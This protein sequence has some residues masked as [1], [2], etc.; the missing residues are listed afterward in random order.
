[1]PSLTSIARRLSD[2]A[3]GTA[4]DRALERSRGD[5]RNAYLFFWNRGLGDIALGLVPLFDRILERSP[6]AR[7][8]VITR[9]ELRPAF[10]L[11]DASEIHVLSGL[12]R[13]ARVSLDAACRA[14]DLDRA[15]FAE[16][17]E[18]PDPN[19]W[20]EGRRLE[21]PPHLRWNPEWDALAEPL[22][23]SA[24]GAVYAGAHVKSETAQYY[25][26]RK[27]WPDEAW[28]TLF[29]RFE[30]D[31]RV[32]WVLLGYEPRPAYRGAGI[33]D[34]R[35]RTSFPALMSLIRTR[36]RVLVAPDS[37][38]LTTAYY[39]DEPFPLDV[40]SLWADP[41]QGVLHQGC[42]SPNARLRHTPLV[43]PGEDIRNL[44]VDSVE[45]A[46]RGALAALDH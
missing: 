2:R 17:F 42:A 1:M 21:H 40:V 12:T 4:F 10:A 9:E 37:G 24:P 11:T 6:A 23:P 35:G 5:P 38:I 41:R 13:E 22:L 29:E 46:V 26:Y 8:A 3:F 7:I 33:L 36:L 32:R 28:Q 19:R 18:Y 27:D 44:T 14:L 31:G 30:A 25:G 16:V 39:L 43:S 45:A 34:L 15:R 20:L